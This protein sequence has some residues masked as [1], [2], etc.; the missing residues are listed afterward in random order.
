ML[1]QEGMKQVISSLSGMKRM[2]WLAKLKRPAPAAV[3]AFLPGAFF[4]ALGALVAAAPAF[5]TAATAALFVF[6]G[7]FLSL[8]AWKLLE[9]YDRLHGLSRD[10]R[11]QIVVH[12]VTLE[13]GPRGDVHA[14]DSKKIVY[15]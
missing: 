3:I 4:L 15:H 11:A 10:L 2:P 7:V 5:I 6:I 14:P 8:V 12:G 1:P 13:K 9:L